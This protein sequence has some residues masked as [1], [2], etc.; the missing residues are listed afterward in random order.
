MV[1]S[2]GTVTTTPLLKTAPPTVERILNC[3]YMPQ[4]T[5]LWFYREFSR[6][7]PPRETLFVYRDEKPRR[8]NYSAEARGLRGSCLRNRL[9]YADGSAKLTSQICAADREIHGI[10]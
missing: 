6:S 2:M 5:S 7:G 9:P 4:K 8:T 1:Q 3:K 10:L